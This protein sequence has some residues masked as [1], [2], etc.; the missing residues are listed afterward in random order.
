MRYRLDD[1]ID[2]GSAV[3]A[4]GGL[5][6]GRAGR[7]ARVQVE[8]EAFGV[9]THGLKVLRHVI[10]RVSEGAGV[11]RRPALRKES[12]A[13]AAYD[14]EGCVGVECVLTACDEARDRARR[15]GMGLVSVL[16]SDWVG[17]LGYHLASVAREGF[18]CMGWAQMSG[19][20]CV[21]PF[22]G[23][24][25]RLSTNPMAF[26]FPRAGE[27]V[28]AD[29]S[30]AAVASGKV[31]DW[32]AKGERPP[33]PLLLD[34]EG[35]ATDDPTVLKGGGTILPFGGRNY[36]FR[37]TALSMWIEAMTAAAGG[38]PANAEK[39]GGQN[40]HVLAMDIG[41]MNGAGDYEEAMGGVLD[42]VLSSAPAP[43]GPGPMMPGD[44]EWAS[45]GKARAEGLAVEEGL[46][47]SLRELG[48]K[49]GVAFP[50]A[51]V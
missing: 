46:A 31:W 32:C 29:F 8:I 42:Y 4:R 1:L 44:R 24:E 28:V 34:A 14:G 38:V 12:G 6:G 51:T 21:A 9:K 2:W 35:R 30:T 27:P 26:S 18:L 45:L 3:L 43:G 36:G 5:E 16:G 22:G 41:A 25:G 39:K 15:H 13:I 47:D 23:R 19:W 48:E 50:E 33:E 37:G 17:V 40:V 10:Q 7:I 20:P 49:Q 11:E